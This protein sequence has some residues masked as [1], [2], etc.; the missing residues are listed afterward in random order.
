MSVRVALVVEQMWQPVPGGSGRYIVEVASRLGAAGARAL[1]IAAAHGRDEPSPAS[2]GLTIPV[3]NSRLPRRLLYAAWD[4]AGAPEVDHL[5][6]GPSGEADAVHATTWAIPPTSKPLAVTV[7]DVAFVRDPAHFTRHGN[8][9]FRRALDKTR[10]RAGAIIVPSR[11]TADDCVA[12]G[13]DAARITVIPH[14]LTHTPASAD[15]VRAFQEAHGLT[16]PYILWV[17]TREPRKNLPTLLRAFARLAPAS[18]L[19]LVLVGPAGW[20]EDA[21]EEASLAEEIPA[22]RLHVLGRLGDADLAA[23]YAGARAFTFPSI[24]EGF[25]LPVLE[26]MAHG[27]PVVT[28]AGTC[29]EEVAGDAGLLVDPVDA[30]ALAEALAAAAGTDHDRLAAAGRE[31]ASLFTWEESARAHAAVYQDLVR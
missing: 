27:A 21:T 1:G 18:D 29:M 3:V 16:R 2:V 31:R 9:Y 5:T 17:G 22:G 30:G 12:A 8:A 20:G 6:A 23:A 15:Q 19:D 28:S 7:H 14:G 25:G 13:L 11:A 26:A 4:R 24:W 10:R